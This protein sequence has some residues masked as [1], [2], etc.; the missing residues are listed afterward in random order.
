MSKF[1]KRFRFSSCVI[2]T[3]SKYAWVFPLKDKK[4]ITTTNAFQKIL[5]NASRKPSNTWLDKRSEFYS[6]S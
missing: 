6:T 2:D 1:N 5:K 3:F 4:S